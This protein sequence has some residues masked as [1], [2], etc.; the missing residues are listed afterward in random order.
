MSEYTKSDI[1][2]L[3]NGELP[4]ERVQEIMRNP[5]DLDRFDK[6]VDVCQGEVSWTEKIL[7]PH[8]ANLFIVEKGDERLIKCRCGY[9]FGDYRVNWKLNALIYVRDTEEKLEEIYVGR[10]QPDTDW[11]QLREYYCPECGIQHCVEAVPRGCPPDFE[12]LPD[13]DAFYDEILG[14]PLSNKKEFV[15]KSLDYIDSW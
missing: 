7:L 15:D 3:V 11:C 2:A 10:Q 12:Y 4:W 5:K 8:S 14:E 13:I 9:E 1:R 6:W